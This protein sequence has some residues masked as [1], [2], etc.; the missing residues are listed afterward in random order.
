LADQ[1]GLRKFGFHG[2][3][4]RYVVTQAA[5]L[6][7]RPL[8]TLNAVSCH[9]GSG[10]ASLCAVVG[11]RS[12]DNTMGYSPLA[13]LI[14]STRCGDLDPAVTLQL[15]AQEQGDLARV[16]DLLNNRCGVLGLSESSADIRDVLPSDA[17]GRSL[18]K[19]AEGYL[20]RIRKYLGAYLTVAAPADAV[21]F[22][23]TVGETVP[24]VRAGAC[25]G[26]EAFGVILDPDANAAASTAAALPADV[27]VANSPVRVLVIATN[28]ELA[29]ARE[30]YRKLSC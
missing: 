7:G 6:L 23:D 22:T 3:S 25:S 18:N 21:V 8:E 29:M 11:G 27:A 2:I 17:K 5:A 14:M 15:V 19:T 26:L 9:L 28:E 4:H 30:A 16:E 20:W 13:G 24:F 1:L 10:G 12:V